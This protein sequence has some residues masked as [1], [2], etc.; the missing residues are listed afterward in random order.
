MSASARKTEGSFRRISSRNKVLASIILFLASMVV[1]TWLNSSP[2]KFG[3]F[4]G[5]NRQEAGL[6]AHDRMAV[7]HGQSAHTVDSVVERSALKD[8][9][10]DFSMPLH[11]QLKQL[12]LAA[13]GGD[14]N[15]IC[16][17]VKSLEHCNGIHR[18]ENNNETLFAALLRNSEDKDD[19]EEI[20]DE[21][22]KFENDIDKAQA[23]CSDLSISIESELTRRLLQAADHGDI[24]AMERLI[25]DPPLI[26]DTPLSVA[27]A[28]ILYKTKAP[29]VLN[30]MAFYGN[31]K[32]IQ[33]L[34]DAHSSGVISTGFGNVPVERDSELLAAVADVLVELGDTDVR[35][36]VSERLA[37]GAIKSAILTSKRSAQ[38]RERL[39][40][41]VMDVT[42]GRSP[43]HDFGSNHH[44]PACS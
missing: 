28:M 31:M 10:I 18:M 20:V 37:S 34:Y 11:S 27:E 29:D 44:L 14:A 16:R 30:K 41:S 40:K 25:F 42:N 38:L 26:S 7:S 12:S 24:D 1:Y 8:S 33:A 17:L 4:A 23:F 21:I 2:G 39:R 9:E 43:H 13:D 3:V 36:D 19:S 32:A 35:K 15:A 22:I 5:E 6:Q